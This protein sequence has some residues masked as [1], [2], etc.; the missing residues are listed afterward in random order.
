[1]ITWR[2]RLFDPNL[3]FQWLSGVRLVDICSVMGVAINDAQMAN[4]IWRSK[5]S[6]DLAAASLRGSTT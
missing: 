3:S 1:M 6:R 4:S 5:P 2:K